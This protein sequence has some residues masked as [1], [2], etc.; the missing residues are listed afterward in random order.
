VAPVRGGR[1]RRS[2]GTLPAATPPAP[3]RPTISSLTT[4]LW[5]SLGAIL[6]ANARYLVQRVAA[7]WFGAAFPYGT[8][9]VNGC[10]AV[11]VAVTM[12][13]GRM[14]DRPEVVRLVL[15]VG[16]LG[17]LTTFSA[18]AWETHGLFQD[19]AWVRAL[20]NIVLSVLAGLAGVRL[21]I[22]LT[23]KLGGLL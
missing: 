20:A 11:G 12:V 4:F 17:S 7:Q 15:I 9:A 2:G 3:R 21:G 16:F 10:V 23:P 5:I 8:L 1:R 13:T 18:F 6:G 14:I 19:G 22:L